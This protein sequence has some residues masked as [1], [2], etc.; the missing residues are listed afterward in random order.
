MKLPVPLVL[1]QLALS[2]A[3]CCDSF[4]PPQQAEVRFSDRVT[5]PRFVR[6]YPVA[7]DSAHSHGGVF[8]DGSGVILPLNLSVDSTA[9]VFRRSTGQLD[10]LLI[11]YRRDLTL[12]S[13]CNPQYYQRVI[14]GDVPRERQVET[15]FGQVTNVVFDSRQSFSEVLIEIQP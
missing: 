13:G 12:D 1:A 11:R 5:A 14:P 10:T 2:L 7:G 15:T 3:S 6:V 9:Y 8:G 4:P